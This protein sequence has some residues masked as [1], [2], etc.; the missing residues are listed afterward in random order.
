VL[1]S[2]GWDGLTVGEESGAW[3]EDDVVG[4]EG[5]DFGMGA[6]VEAGSDGGFDG[7]T[8]DESEDEGVGF[9]HDEASD[10]D[11]G[12]VVV[13]FDADAC[14]GEHAWAEGEGRVWQVGLSEHGAGGWVEGVSGAG[15]GGVEGLGGERADGGFDGDALVDEWGF[16]FC[17]RDV[18][19][20]G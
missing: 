7:F 19:T 2:G 4:F 13:F 1:G 12:G 8:V 11:E 10:G 20:D 6:V 14:G 18:E 3:E 15:D 9:F 5:R 16:E 17:D